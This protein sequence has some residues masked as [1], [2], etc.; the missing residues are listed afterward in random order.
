LEYLALHRAMPFLQRYPPRLDI[1]V[2][3]TKRPDD[4]PLRGE[5][6]RYSPAEDR[7]ERVYQSPLDVPVPRAPDRMMPRDVG[8]RGVAL[9]TGRDGPDALY[10]S[11]VSARMIHAELPPPRLLRST[12]GRTFE[13]VPQDAGTLMGSIDAVGFRALAVH[14]GRLFAC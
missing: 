6:W 13:A 12:D 8:Y 14:G 9:F 3:C 11:G 10:I 4:L 5:I 2:K 7:W 1:D